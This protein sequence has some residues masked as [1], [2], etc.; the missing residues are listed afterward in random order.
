MNDPF[1][2]CVPAEISCTRSMKICVFCMADIYITY[3][4]DVTVAI[5]K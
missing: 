4:V 5:L 1:K 3:I 2:I